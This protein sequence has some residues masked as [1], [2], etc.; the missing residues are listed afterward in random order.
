MPGSF[1]HDRIFEIDIAVHVSWLIIF[2]L[3]I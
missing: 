3:F 2:V 1:R